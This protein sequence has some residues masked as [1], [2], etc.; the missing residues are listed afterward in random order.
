MADTVINPGAAGAGSG[1]QGAR[2]V[3]F[4]GRRG[5]LFGILMMN[6]LLGFLTLGI[7]RFW[8]R[9]RL[10]QFFWNSIEIDGDVLEYTGRGLELF[11]GFLIV[12]AVLVP[13]AIGYQLLSVFL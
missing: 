4:W 11:I 8:A 5:A 7:Y 2:I 10:R 6:T 1:A 13:L 3:G 12:V 9:T